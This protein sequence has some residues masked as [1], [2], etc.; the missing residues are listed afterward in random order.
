MFR[1]ILVFLVCLSVLS[2]APFTCTLIPAGYPTVRATGVA[3]KVGDVLLICVGGTFMTPREFDV[4]V[5]LSVPVTSANS[6]TNKTDA[7]LFVDEPPRPN[8]V[9]GQNVILGELEPPAAGATASHTLRFRGVRTTEGGDS[10][11]RALRITNLRGNVSQAA[12]AGTSVSPVNATVD[13]SPRLDGL[14]ATGLVAF[15]AT[16][17][18]GY[19][20]GPTQLPGYQMAV[21]VNEAN[22]SDFRKQVNPN[23]DQEPLGI[24]NPT[25][26][27]Y[28]TPLFQSSGVPKTG[29]ANSGTR[30][31]LKFSNVP[32][33]QQVFVSTRPVSVLNQMLDM[34]LTAS[35]DAGGAGAY[36]EVTPTANTPSPGI[37]PVT[38]TNGQG[39]AVYEVLETD[40]TAID[41]AVIGIVLQG[42]SGMPTVQA[43]Y[44]PL[45]DSPQAWIPRFIQPQSGPAVLPSAVFRDTLSRIRVT[46]YGGT[47]AYDAGGVF[48]GKPG[49]AQDGNGDTWI[50]GRDTSNGLYITRFRTATKTFDNW[51]FLGGQAKGDPS[52]GVTAS[53]TVYYTIRDSW[54]SCW[55]GIFRPG[56]GNTWRHLG[57]ILAT[58]P[59]LTAT[60]SDVWIAGKDGW[61]G[62]WTVTVPEALSGITATNWTFRGGIVQGQIS[63]SH[64]SQ[65]PVLAVRDGWNALWL[66]WHNG[67]VWTWTAA[68]G[69]MSRD[70]QMA[71]RSA[72]VAVNDSISIRPLDA[73]FAVTPWVSTG[74]V[75]ASEGAGWLNDELYIAGRDA[76]N[77]IWWYRGGTQPQ[78]SFAGLQGVA[79]SGLTVVPR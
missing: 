71:G 22:T 63:F 33:G 60:Y 48:V 50:V 20:V 56:V 32:V 47:V 3:D 52:V 43:M 69:I 5:S 15:R 46:E 24:V 31:V 75:L 4:T 39:M 51:I 65:T 77:G 53:G 23:Q 54:D 70:P 16:T 9:A 45:T 18:L 37:A 30:V 13:T 74:G 38:I 14:P 68:Q 1:V 73:N 28:T 10:T 36:S 17:P 6:T 19:T 11:A 21:S 59:Q 25:E 7:V 44:G 55:L 40:T 66:G 26:S 49:A 76:T 61:G 57:G 58:D 41:T 27:G 34:R 72:V 12:F 64:Y 42:G 2:A 62:I 8:W 79:A 35:G 29:L 67:Q 78:W